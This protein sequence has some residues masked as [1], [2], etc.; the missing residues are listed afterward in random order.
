V[1]LILFAVAIYGFWSALG[2]KPAFGMALPEE[3]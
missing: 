2:G 3:P 1:R